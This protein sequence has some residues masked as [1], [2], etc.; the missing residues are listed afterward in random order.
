MGIA[1]FQDLCLDAT[2]PAAV[3]DFWAG[4]LGLTSP[5]QARTD[6][7][8]RLD[9]PSDRPE[10][11]TLW[12]N[13]VP[14]PR[15]A[16]TRVHVDVRLGAPDPA[17]LLAAGARVVRHPAEDPWWVLSDPEGNEFCAF[18][19]R[20]GARPGV[21]EL[22]VDSA[23]PAAQARWWAGVVGGEVEVED[24]VASVVGAAG[25]PWEYWVFAAVPEPRTVKNRMHWDVRLTADEPAALL[26]AGA[27]M[28]RE[29]ADRTPWWVLADPEGNEFCAFPRS[30][31]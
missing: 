22:V 8:I 1:R 5:D 27:T 23:D 11:E 2:A 18:A 17:A 13:P 15:S 6:E 16:K 31:H 12:V 25:F 21:F 14:E 4:A 19:P 30:E 26:R 7:V 28:L 10:A 9:P 24:A 3:A 29:P 20:A